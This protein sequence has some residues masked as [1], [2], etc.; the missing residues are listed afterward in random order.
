MSLRHDVAA[1]HRFCLESSRFE[2]V[3]PSPCAV[4]WGH[5]RQVPD[6]PQAVPDRIQ[7]GARHGPDRGQAR[8]GPDRKP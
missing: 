7:T 2:T 1:L 4:V 8:Q 5:S 3:A 6:S